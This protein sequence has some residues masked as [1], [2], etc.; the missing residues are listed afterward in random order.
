MREYFFRFYICRLTENLTNPD[1]ARHYKG[2]IKTDH[3]GRKTPKHAHGTANLDRQT[4]STRLISE[5]TLKLYD[6]I[7]DK[8]M[9]VR[10]VAIAA[11]NLVTEGY[12]EN[13]PYYEQIDLF[14]D[15]E[16]LTA[17]R[18]KQEK[19]LQKERKIQ[20][21]MIVKKTLWQE[22]NYQGY[23]PTRRCYLN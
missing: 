17:E 16:A 18:E 19:E 5:A 3:Y 21:A 4:S 15:Y 14:T 10:R 11:N 22:R 6:E 2:E 1:I 13:K 7:V 23:K 9:L 20:E 12:V 8:K